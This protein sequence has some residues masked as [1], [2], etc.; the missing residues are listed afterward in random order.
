MINSHQIELDRSA[1]IK[2][3]LKEERRRRKK[4]EEIKKEKEREN[5]ER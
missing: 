1:K 4:K 2:S 5:A 3:G